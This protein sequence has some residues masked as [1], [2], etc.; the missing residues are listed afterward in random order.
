MNAAETE[1]LKSI[2][3]RKAADAEYAKELLK[4]EGAL[5]AIATETRLE[6]EQLEK[7]SRHA[8]SASKTEGIKEM[9]QKRAE[10]ATYQKELMIQRNCD[11]FF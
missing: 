4:N 7:D 5:A 3:A 6:R 8:S 10:E 11:E 9:K 1:G 2:K